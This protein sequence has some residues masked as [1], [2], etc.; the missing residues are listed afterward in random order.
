[1]EKVSGQDLNWFFNQWFLD[2]GHPVL[3]I[4][5]QYDATTQ[6]VKVKVVQKQ[7]FEN[8]PLYKL[9]IAIDVYAGGLTNRYEVVL[10]EETEVFTFPS[11]VEPNLV[12]VDAEKVL[13]CQKTDHKSLRQFIYQ[14]YNAPL[15]LDR[16][17]A[18]DKCAADSSLIAVNTILDALDD[19]F[20]QIRLSSIGQLDYGVKLNPNKVKLKLQKLARHDKD[21]KVRAEAIFFLA[22]YF[23]EDKNLAGVYQNALGDRSYTVMGEGMNALFKINPTQ[24]EEVAA[25]HQDAKVPELKEAVAKVYSQ[26]GNAKFHTYFVKGIKNST[27]GDKYQ[28]VNVYGQY[29]SNAKKD[30]SADAKPIF[31][32]IAQNADIWWVKLAPY[33]AINT[34]LGKKDAEFKALSEELKNTTDEAQ[35]TVLKEK[36]IAKEA[37]MNTWTT[38][39]TELF[40]LQTDKKVMK[41]LQGF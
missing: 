30:F 27:G 11:A 20:W 36:V 25:Q 9:P 4:T 38:L 1:M 32:D 7:D 13:L 2:K 10:D 14:Y 19:S 34:V 26:S 28:M 23:P 33:Q 37:E 5:Q 15:Y 8:V 35:I 6:E 21:A 3:D 41:Y 17:E 29:L 16:K 31:T 24:A 40:Q 39:L 22:K 18:L 12:N